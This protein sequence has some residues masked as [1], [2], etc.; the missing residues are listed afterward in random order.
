VEITRATLITPISR[1]PR[2]WVLRKAYLKAKASQLPLAISSRGKKFSRTTDHSTQMLEMAT[3]KTNTGCL[4]MTPPLALKLP[5]IRPNIPREADVMQ[6]M[7]LKQVLIQGKAALTLLLLPITSLSKPCM[8]APRRHTSPSGSIPAHRGIGAPA[9]T[10]EARARE[11]GRTSSTADTRPPS[12]NHAKEPTLAL[13][14]DP[15]HRVYSS[16]PTA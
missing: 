7:Q 3:S 12:V 10:A 2:T 4:A 15:V 14:P 11:D 16:I 8:R 1:I 6:L 13:R 5:H 9:L